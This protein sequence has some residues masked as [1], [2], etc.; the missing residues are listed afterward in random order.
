MLVNSV[1]E[2]ARGSGA[3]DSI[4]EER[5]RWRQHNALVWHCTGCRLK[6]N[7]RVYQNAVFPLYSYHIR[8]NDGALSLKDAPASA[9]WSSLHS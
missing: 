3:I 7:K 8:S 9:R 5:N 6:K 1:L 2:D 4:A